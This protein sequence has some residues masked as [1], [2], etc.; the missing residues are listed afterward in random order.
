[1]LYHL[2]YSL[3]EYWSFFNIFR[4]I[5]FRT[6]YASLTA[7]ILSLLLGRFFITTLRKLQINQQIRDDGPRSHL[8]KTG[9]PTMGGILIIT[10]ILFSTLL[11]SDLRNS[12]IWLTVLVAF[13]FALIG[14]IDD[15]KKVFQ[16][17]PKGLKARYKLMVQLAISLC[18]AL[19][20]FGGEE[21][22]TKISIPFFKNVNPDLGYLYLPFVILIIVG[23]SNAINLTDG[24]DG[25]AIGQIVIVGATYLLFSYLVGNVKT[26]KYLQILYIEG[27][28]ELSILCGAMVGASMGFLWYNTFPAEL[29]MGDVGSLSLGGILGSVAVITKQEIL[30]AIVGGICVLETVS[31]IIQVCSF[32]LSGKRV[33]KMAPLHHH[34]ELRGIPEPKI[35]VRFWIISIVL[36]LIAVS[37]LK[38]R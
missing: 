3:H 25:L 5:T 12:Y 35:I 15:Y 17:N 23:A 31:V 16:R 30:L 1:M 22:C 11:W 21:F 10:S 38:I 20:L 28:G 7:L 27:A 4:Y 24:L 9:T 29:F 6:I 8:E 36:A 34:Y 19:I 14:F 18:V 37:T 2:L 13:S 26:A 33:F 32:K